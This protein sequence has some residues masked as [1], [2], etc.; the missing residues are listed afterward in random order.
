MGRLYTG[1]D[2]FDAV[3]AAAGSG[4]VPNIFIKQESIGGGTDVQALFQSGK[5]IDMLRSAGAL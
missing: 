4:T 3:V 5:L 2:Q 1:A